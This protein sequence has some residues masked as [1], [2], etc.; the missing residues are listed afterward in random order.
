MK[1]ASSSHQPRKGFPVPSHMGCP[2]NIG[3]ENETF[4]TVHHLYRRKI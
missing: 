1:V 3:M 4:I 2:E